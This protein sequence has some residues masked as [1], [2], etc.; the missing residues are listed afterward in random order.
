MNTRNHGG[1][2]AGSGGKRGSI[3]APTRRKQ[4]LQ[5]QWEALV[6]LEFDAIVEAQL[7]AAI[8]TSAVF[9]TRPDGTWVHHPDPDATILARV[10]AGDEALRLTAVAPNHALLKQI[11]DRLLGRPC[12]ALEVELPALPQ[13]SD[14]DL[15][16]PLAALLRRWQ[17]QTG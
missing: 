8:G 11:F 17:P 1:K 10:Q 7:R 9:A 13:V 6:A 4:A 5:A 16:A 2:R 14:A 15:A 3:Y 12:E